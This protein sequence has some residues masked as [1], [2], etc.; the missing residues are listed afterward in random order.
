VNRLEQLHK[1]LKSDPE[2]PFLSYAIAMEHI[3]LKNLKKAKQILL[4]LKRRRPDYT[5]MYYHLGK[6]Y[7]GEGNNEEA[8]L[9]YREGIKLTTVSRQQ[10]QLAELQTALNNMLYDE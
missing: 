9:I 2:D 6:L 8:E 4:E 1:Y 7:Q 5:A 3:G 10:H